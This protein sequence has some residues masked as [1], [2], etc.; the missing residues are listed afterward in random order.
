MTAAQALTRIEAIQRKALVASA[1]V[2][3]AQVKPFVPIDTGALRDSGKVVDNAQ[4]NE[5]FIEFGGK[6]S[7]PR[8]NELKS[9]SVYV[10]NQYSKAKKHFL[11][12]GKLGALLDL[13]TGESKKRQTGG[14]HRNRYAA[15]YRQ[16]IKNDSLTVFPNG[17]RWFKI[18]L[19]SAEI[20]RKMASAYAR[21]ARGN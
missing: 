9:P 5:V 8:K 13:F 15:A 17:V 4:D 18:I 10:H 7:R 11:T 21:A 16:A 2:A 3:L 12:G 6:G 1:Y 19:R 14:K 20:K